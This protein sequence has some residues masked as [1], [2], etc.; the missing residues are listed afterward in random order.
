MSEF[1]FGLAALRGA[2]KSARKD[3]AD[4]AELRKQT[5]FEEGASFLVGRTLFVWVS[6]DITPDDGVKSIRPESVSDTACGRLRR[7][8]FGHRIHRR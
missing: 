8:G 1:T 4:V 2:V 5:S 3:V 7:A 6:G